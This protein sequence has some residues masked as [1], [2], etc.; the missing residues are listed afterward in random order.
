[1]F[2][3]AWSTCIF[4]GQES[5]RIDRYMIHVALRNHTAVNVMSWSP[6]L[7]NFKISP[8]FKCFYVFLVH[9]PTLASSLKSF[10]MFGAHQKFF[11]SFWNHCQNHIHHIHPPGIHKWW[12][13]CLFQWKYPC[14]GFHGWQSIIMRSGRVMGHSNGVISRSFGP[15]WNEKMRLFNMHVVA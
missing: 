3:D 11:E 14:Y 5:V 9:F 7:A 8:C 10:E 13:S 1:M 4:V 12:I 15:C 6:C 2:Y